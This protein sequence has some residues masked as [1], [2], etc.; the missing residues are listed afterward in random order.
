MATTQKQ[1]AQHLG[2]SQALVAQA[3]RGYPGVAET[4]RQRIVDTAREMG[5]STLDNAAAR[6]LIAR[7]HGNKVTIGA[8]AILM[9]DFLDGLPLQN[10]PFFNEILQGIHGEASRRGQDVSIHVLRPGNLPRIVTSGNID[11]AIC[12]YSRTISEDLINQQVQIPAVR[13]GQ[14]VEGEATICP[15]DRH[16][17]Y[18]ATR[19]LIR[20]GH[21][22]IAYLGGWLNWRR[23]MAQK[24]RYQGYLDALSEAG[25]S[26]DPLLTEGELQGPS[27]SEGQRGA[28]HLLAKSSSF[29]ALVC[30]NDPVALGAIEAI[31]S[32]G[33]RVPEDISV[34]GF[35]GTP[36][37]YGGSSTLTTIYFDRREMGRRAV[38]MLD[39]IASSPTTSKPQHILPVQLLDRD[40][41]AAL[42]P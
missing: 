40:S 26:A 8:I 42:N 32:Q 21:R 6:S 13:L 19:H 33:L 9:G 36:I 39:E 1:I 34:T 35:D 38:E 14:Y 4:T 27:L 41:T 7:R 3:L 29:T 37:G 28:L 30:S 20:L 2:L 22:R 25:M 17:T 12:I 16:G 10:M 31:K 5:Y 24:L 18:E 11:G 23:D 15:D